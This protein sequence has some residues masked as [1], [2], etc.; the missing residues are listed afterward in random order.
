MGP[1]GT[2][3]NLYLIGLGNTTVG[4]NDALKAIACALYDIGA[5]RL[6]APRFKSSVAL[7]DELKIR[8]V[9]VARID[10]YGDFIAQ[11]SGPKAGT[12]ETGLMSSMKEIFTVGYSPYDTPAGKHDRSVTIYAPQ[13]TVAGFSTEK[14]FFGAM[15]SRDIVGGFLNRHGA[16]YEHEMTPLNEAHAQVWKLPPTLKEGLRPLFKPRTDL[17]NLLKTKCTKEDLEALVA[18]PFTP[19]IIMTWGPGAKEI[20]TSFAAEMRAEKDEV[21]RDLFGRAAEIAVKV[22]TVVAYGRGS[23]TVDRCDMLLG[24]EFALQS[25]EIIYA[26]VLKYMEDPH[27]FPALCRKII[28]LLSEAPEKRMSLRDINRKCQG[29]ISRGASIE[30]ALKF[31]YTAERIRYEERST[32]GRPTVIVELLTED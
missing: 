15:K 12:Y 29:I 1:T 16:A 19:E 28:E 27:N 2:G 32:G 20:F 13:A 4:K 30:E 17:S 25:A 22:G 26:G 9:F 24:K 23:N 3:P 11:M 7:I 6:V 21:R 10:E 18:M 14:A 31:L 8:P 5:K